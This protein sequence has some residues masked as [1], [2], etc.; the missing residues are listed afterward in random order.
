M[1]AMSLCAEEDDIPWDSIRDNRDLT[2]FTSW[3]P[4]ERSEVIYSRP[5]PPPVVL[6]CIC[7]RVVL[8][9]L[10]AVSR[11]APA[12]FP[13]RGDRLAENTLPHASPRRFH[14]VAGA[15]VHAAERR[16][17]RE[18]SRRQGVD[19]QQPPDAAQP[20]V[21]DG[22]SAGRETDTGMLGGA[23]PSGGGG[24]ALSGG[25]GLKQKACWCCSIHSWDRPPHAWPP[26]CPSGAASA[27]LQ[28][29]SC[30]STCRSW[31]CSGSV[32]RPT[33]H[34]QLVGV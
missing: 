13:R 16:D 29:S 21:T 31:S 20:D 24:A 17:Q 19:P 4:K 7:L 12:P 2:V 15:H 6:C 18:R 5:P 25:G 14:G 11:G 34:R 23:A 32:R 33:T 8:L 26:L 10:Q 9:R 27:R 30:A 1:K 28:P 3:D 22:I